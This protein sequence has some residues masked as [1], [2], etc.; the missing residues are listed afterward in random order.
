MPDMNCRAFLITTD[1]FVSFDS[2]VQHTKWS[3]DCANTVLLSAANCSAY[4]RVDEP[5]PV[6]A[7]KRLRASAWIRG[8][9]AEY[10]RRSDYYNNKTSHGCSLFPDKSFSLS[11]PPV[12]KFV[13][14]S[15]G[16]IIYE[17]PDGLSQL[18]VWLTAEW[19][20]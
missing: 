18:R 20:M 3:M 1:G 13:K 19:V 16:A 6:W 12:H 7:I 10:R 5:V 8:A 14:T 11:G 17:S 9:A 2:T 15:L 4:S